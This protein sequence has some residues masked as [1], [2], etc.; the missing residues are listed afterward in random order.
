ML[1]KVKVD[2]KTKYNLRKKLQQ[3]LKTQKLFKI[4]TYQVCSSTKIYYI[5]KL[6]KKKKCNN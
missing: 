3:K 6:N 4:L 2:K 1:Q 5:K